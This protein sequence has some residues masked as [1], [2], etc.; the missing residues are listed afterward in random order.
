MATASTETVGQF[1]SGGVAFPNI[2]D[3]AYG[4]WSGWAYSN[5]NDT[6]TSGRQSVCGLFGQRA[7][8]SRA[9]ARPMPWPMGVQ[10]YGTPP[11]ITLPG[12]AK[13]SA[14]TSR[15]RPTPIFPCSRRLLREEVR[16][17]GLVPADHQRLRRERPADGN[18]SI[19]IWRKG[20]TS[21]PTG[22]TVDLTSLGDDV[23]SLQFDLTSSDNGDL[24]H[25]YARLFCPGRLDIA[26]VP[27]LR[28]LR[29][30]AA[31]A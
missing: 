22:R 10:R 9:P 7:A 21:S 4:S 28:R 31:L 18:A 11:T 13:C 27:S 26:T 3:N 16:R 23:K 5:V 29:C 12:P 14:P 1:T 8:E 2:Y 17:S 15:T 6:T 20:R 24:R 19:S 25:E 30:C